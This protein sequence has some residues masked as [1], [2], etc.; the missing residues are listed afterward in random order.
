MTQAKGVG[1][2][3][4][5]GRKAPRDHKVPKAPRAPRAPRDL[6]VPRARKVLGMAL[7]LDRQTLP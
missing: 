7:A 1:L 4:I 6:K 2:R 3:L 5:R